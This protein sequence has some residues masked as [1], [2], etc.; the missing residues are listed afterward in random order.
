MSNEFSDDDFNSDGFFN[1]R[2]AADYYMIDLPK[3]TKRLKVDRAMLIRAIVVP[4]ITTNSPYKEPGK[5]H[6]ARDYYVFRG[7]GPDRK[8]TYFDCMATFNERCPI[9]DFYREN[10]FKKK[11]QRKALFNLYVLDIDGKEVNELMVLDHSYFNFAEV[12]DTARVGMMKRP[13]REW[14]SMFTHPVNGA[15]LTWDFLEETYEGVKFYKAANFEFEKHNGLDGKIKQ[16]VSQAVDLDKALNKLDY[17]DAKRRF[18][19]GIGS[20]PAKT[21]APKTESK[22]ADT[23]TKPNAES[24]K[25]AQATAAATSKDAFDADADWT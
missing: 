11:P 13:G 5:P 8:Q 24:E 6:F 7:L 17:D 12:L 4:Y 3:N 9:G 19:D 10:K 14:L 25:V 1:G 22:P 21:E 23:A 16:L 18:I 2:N 20:A 15:I